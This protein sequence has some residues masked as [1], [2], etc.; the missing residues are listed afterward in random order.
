M[1]DEPNQPTGM[2][3][4]E[5]LR[6]LVRQHF[7]VSDLEEALEVQKQALASLELVAQNEV[8]SAGLKTMPVTTPEPAARVEVIGNGLV[9]LSLSGLTPES[10]AMIASDVREM[11]AV[12]ELANRTSP[13]HGIPMNV[14]AAQVMTL[15]RL[16]DVDN[17]NACATL[18]DAGFAELVRESYNANT[19]SAVAREMLDQ[20]AECEEHAA[21]TDAMDTDATDAIA[22]EIKSKVAK[23]R[24]AFEFKT[25]TDVRVTRAGNKESRS[26]RAARTLKKL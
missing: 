19:V 18:K 6:A 10:V 1:T 13:R 16:E 20:L 8:Q 3:N 24:R 17:E 12:Q 26:S 21:A 9:L 11:A 2:I 23:L 15:S 22:A 7:L 4:L 14:T 25:R 5:A